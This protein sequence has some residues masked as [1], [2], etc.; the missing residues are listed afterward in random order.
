MGSLESII[1]YF[2]AFFLV[3]VGGFAWQ[4]ASRLSKRIRDFDISIWI[5]DV[6]MSVWKKRRKKN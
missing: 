6:W 4:L 5:I 1:L 3:F 2:F